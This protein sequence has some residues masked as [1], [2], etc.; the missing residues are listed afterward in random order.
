MSVARTDARA[1]PGDLVHKRRGQCYALEMD[2]TSVPDLIQ[3]FGV[4][5]P[6]EPLT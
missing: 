3:R 2:P 6:A 5:F 4:R 1:G